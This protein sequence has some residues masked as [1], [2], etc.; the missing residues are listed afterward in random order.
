MVNIRIVSLLT[1]F[2]IHGMHD[3]DYLLTAY[4]AKCLSQPQNWISL[5]AELEFADPHIACTRR[6]YLSCKNRSRPE[7]WPSVKYQILCD[8]RI[9]PLC[10]AVHIF[11]ATIVDASY[12]DLSLAF[13]VYVHSAFPMSC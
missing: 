3:Y 10:N 5:L 7:K 12:C 9:F 8:K 6:N 13:S 2:E 1:S 11:K 4:D